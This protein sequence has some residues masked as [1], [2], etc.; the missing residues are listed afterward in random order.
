MLSHNS[1]CLSVRVAV[2]SSI[3]ASDGG[4]SRA[5]I[6]TRYNYLFQYIVRLLVRS[7]HCCTV[8][9]IVFSIN[10]SDLN[11]GEIGCLRFTVIINKERV[12][13]FF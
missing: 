12:F 7:H 10:V 5:Y 11:D 2:G 8:F 9:A 13:F 1:V 3:L 4:D 6:L